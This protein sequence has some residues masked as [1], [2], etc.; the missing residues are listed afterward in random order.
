MNM[1]S[2]AAVSPCNLKKF[3]ACLMRMKV[4]LRLF[5]RLPFD[6][7]NT[8]DEEILD[9]AKARKS[10]RVRYYRKEKIQFNA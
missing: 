3:S 4:H 2:T 6:G 7:F 9:E 5:S 8:E 10:K 1:Y